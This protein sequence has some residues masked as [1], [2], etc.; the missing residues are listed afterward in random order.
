MSHQLHQFMSWMALVDQIISSPEILHVYLNYFHKHLTLLFID[1]GGN[2]T[3][4]TDASLGF[5]TFT[6]QNSTHLLF[7]HIRSDDLSVYDTFTIYKPDFDTAKS[8]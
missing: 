8:I 2:F 6:I 1:P 3:A 7:E 5:S 4:K